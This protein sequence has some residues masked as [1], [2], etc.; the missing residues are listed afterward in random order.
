[1]GKILKPL[2]II[3]AIAVN[4]IPGAGQAISGAIF[5]VI[6]TGTFAAL[7]IATTLSGIITTGLTLAGLSAL[8]GG[9]GGASSAQLS[10]L[11][12]SFNAEAPRKVW[13]G[14][15]AASTDALYQEGS[16]T[17][18]EY[19]DLIVAVAAH[20]TDAITAIWSEDKVMWTLAGGVQGIYAGYLTVDIVLEGTRSNG[21]AINGGGRWNSDCTL[22]GCA[23]VKLRVKRTGATAKASSPFAAGIPSR[24]T[25]EGRGG[26][27]YDPRRDSTAGGSGSMRATDQTTWA[28]TSGGVPLGNNP[29]LQALTFL[30]GWKS[31]GVVSVGAG[32]PPSRLA[33]ADWIA[34]ANVCDEVITT[35]TGSQ[36]RYETHGIFSDDDDPNAVVQSLC[37]HMNAYL[38]DVGGK[39][40]IRMAI[41]DLGGGLVSFDEGDILGHHDWQ[42]FVPL[43]ESYNVVRGKWTDPAPASLYQVAPYPAQQVTSADTIN[44]T[45]TLDLPL[46][47]DPVRAQR[48]ARQ[49][50]RRGQLKGTF[51]ADFGPRG[52]A[53]ELG[54][55]V[56]L[57]FAAIGAVSKLFRVV[58]QELKII[59][60]ASDAAAVCPM[61][62]IEEDASIYAWSSGDALATD[63]A[64]TPVSY[65]P[66][67]Q[68]FLLTQ[69]TDIGVAN[70]ADVTAT[71]LATS[72]IASGVSIAGVSAG[73]VA[74]AVTSGV[75]PVSSVPITALGTSGS[76]A[77]SLA[78][79]ASRTFHSEFYYG[80]LTAASTASVPLEYRIGGGSWTGFGTSSPDSGAIADTL[81]P[82]ATGTLTNSG[83]S[84]L[85]YEV[86]CVPARTGA[87]GGSVDAS[88]SRL[89]G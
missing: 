54:Q 9:G 83:G 43:H 27:V 24:M 35:T 57:T 66:A 56:T 75:S 73:T 48:I 32:M 2:L 67:S 15:T 87:S 16:G 29:A 13:L 52:W 53:V 1:M 21:I 69:G 7:G 65:L 3:A 60:S 80:P 44:R 23:Y 82:G 63:A 40:G 18:Q 68:P 72:G 37:T 51:T 39:L 30:I 59:N 42:P 41:N 34:A 78:P 11:N 70:G 61:T 6:G 77:F 22:T 8:G 55:P 36:R 20:P 14:S 50:L 5:G 49:V 84:A 19:I 85:N 88:L 76:I 31:G 38:R 33:M 81:V 86:R 64:V 10:R 74:A 62:L 26:K 28:Y 12:L 71:A 25:I 17:D 89:A 4:V 47:Q 79:G 58:R 45:L 46:V